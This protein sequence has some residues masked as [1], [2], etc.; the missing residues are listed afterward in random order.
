MFRGKDGYVS[1]VPVLILLSLLLSNGV[2]L[3]GVVDIH[4]SI[5][6]TGSTLKFLLQMAI[7]V[8]LSSVQQS[9]F[10]TWKEVLV[11]VFSVVS[12]DIFLSSKTFL[13]YSAGKGI[14]VFV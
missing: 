14:V 2:L 6:H 8:I 13:A 3:I 7:Q 9:A 4:G 10:A 12:I 11:V 1:N 5:L